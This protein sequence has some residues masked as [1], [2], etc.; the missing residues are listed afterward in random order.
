VIE[1]LTMET[2]TMPRPRPQFLHREVTRH[3]KPVWYVRINRGPRIRLRALF[4]TPEFWSEYRAAIAGQPT[5]PTGMKFNAQTF[6]WLVERYRE[7]SG[8][9]GTWGSLSPGT[10]RLREL[11]LRE[12]CTKAGREPLS[13]ITRAVMERS[14]AARSPNNAKHLLDTMRGLFRWAANAGHCAQDPTAGLTAIQQKSDGHRP[15]PPEWRATY[16]ARWPLGTRERLD[17]EVLFWTGLRVGDAVRLG[18]PHVNKNGIAIIASEKTGKLVPIPMNEYPRL[19]AALAAGPVG[20]LTFIAGTNGRPITKF[21][22]GDR[23]RR[24]ART[25]GVPGS[26]HGLR[27]TRAPL[28]IDAGATNA[29][30]EAL[31]G[32]SRGS[33]M[34]E[35]YTRTRD[36]TGLAER[37]AEKMLANEMRTSILHLTIRC[38]RQGENP[39]ENNAKFMAP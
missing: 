20:E 31:M 15:W 12:S 33:R 14:M 25:A 32:W 34:A 18:R 16:E 39:N 7:S 28:A 8:V 17:Y 11:F 4:G 35:V 22:L 5:V 27:K 24:A 30:L 19:L 26:A 9:K 36:E 3:G 23:F 37:A 21:T 13:R 38:G 2:L 10:R 6:G 29:E 1:G